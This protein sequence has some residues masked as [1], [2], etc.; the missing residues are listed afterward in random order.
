LC[1]PCCQCL[2]VSFRVVYCLPSSCV[3]CVPYCQWLWM[4]HSVLCIVWLPRQTIHNREWNIQSLTTWDTEDTGGRQTKHNTTQ[5]TIK[6]SNTDSTNKTGDEHMCSRR[7][8][9]FCLLINT[10]LDNRIVKSV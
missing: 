4:F 2:D 9:S 1:V 3:L 8:S 5:K 7:V 6:I 10:R